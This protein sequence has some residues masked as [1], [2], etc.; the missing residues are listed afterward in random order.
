[1]PNKTFR[2]LFILIL[3]IV[4]FSFGCLRT[5][6]TLKEPN[7]KKEHL[8]EKNVSNFPEIKLKSNVKI[9]YITIYEKCGH[10]KTEIFIDNKYKGYTKEK[11]AE[12]FNDWK[13]ES[14]KSDEVVLK[15]RINGFCDEHYYVGL[16]DNYV[17]L[18]QGQPGE[19]S[20]VLEK[21]DILADTLRKEDR[22]LLQRGLIIENK[23]EFLNIREGLS[24]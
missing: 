10:E 3:I 6:I 15:K 23:E 19:R 16:L 22:E 8:K 11:F 4:S 13:I 21:T 17:V 5:L 14:F 7:V 18:F 1:M 12:E 20:N 24:K 9:V 2:Y